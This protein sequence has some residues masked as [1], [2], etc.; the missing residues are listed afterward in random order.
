M[1][2]NNS[3]N[4]LNQIK[5]IVEKEIEKTSLLRELSLLLKIDPINYMTKNNATFSFGEYKENNIIIQDINDVQKLDETSN[6][7]IKN[8]IKVRLE[9]LEKYDIKFTNLM[10]S[11]TPATTGGRKKRVPRKRTTK[12]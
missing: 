12:K 3:N 4:Y 9:K 7:T 10:P 6:N 1:N 5:S 11:N 8:S 2:N